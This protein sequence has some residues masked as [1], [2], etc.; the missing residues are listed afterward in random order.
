MG[1]FLK[2][3]VDDAV[4]NIVEIVIGQSGSSIEVDFGVRVE[5]GIVVAGSTEERLN[6]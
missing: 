5:D 4:Q 1:N 3:F 2:L 6:V